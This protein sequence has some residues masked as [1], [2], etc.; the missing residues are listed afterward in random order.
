MIEV[1]IRFLSNKDDVDEK[2]KA[3][4]KLNDVHNSFVSKV[5][6]FSMLILMLA[7][8]M[9][10]SMLSVAL[11]FFYFVGDELEEYKIF[12]IAGSFAAAILSFVFF[13]M[14]RKA[15]RKLKKPIEKELE[16]EL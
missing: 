11:G 13:R 1:L 3:F 7:F 2:I 9:F 5:M 14:M 6:A 10:S 8:F 12:F 16:L 4:N 15:S